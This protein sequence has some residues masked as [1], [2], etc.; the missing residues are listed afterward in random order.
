MMYASEA[1]YPNVVA[2]LWAY[3]RERFPLAIIIPLLLT[4]SISSVSVSAHLSGRRMPELGA[5]SAA[6]ILSLSS[7][8]ALHV[9]QEIRD[10]DLLKLTRP[11]M[12]IQRGLVSIQLIGTL[13]AAAVALALA[14]AYSY[15]EFLLVPLG[16]VLVWVGLVVAGFFAP[17]LVRATPPLHLLGFTLVVP[18]IDFMVTACEWGPRSGTVPPGLWTFLLMSLA[19]GCILEIGGKIRSPISRKARRGYYSTAWGLPASLWT[20]GAFTLAAYGCM[21]AYGAYLDMAPHFA[22]AGL[23]VGIPFLC[24]LVCF[25]IHPVPV[26]EKTVA[27]AS[28]VWIAGCYATAA[29]L[30]FIWD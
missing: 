23:L 8:W 3:Q 27:A 7:F 16:F 21:V 14:V 19:N 1:G 25:A 30:P 4:F 20:L 24:C 18:L 10:A 2:R 9:A 12:P 22:E 29:A 11:D 17:R 6:F 26:L 13:G 28:R 5:Y 15:H